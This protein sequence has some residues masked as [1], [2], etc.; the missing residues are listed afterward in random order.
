VT[1]PTG[2]W[3]YVHADDDAE[4]GR[5]SQLAR[6]VKARYELL[7]GETIEL[8]LDQD[9]LGWGE[10]WRQKVES[11]LATA[12]FFI[13][14]LTPRFF[15]SSE[16]RNELQTFTRKATNLGVRELVLPIVYAEFAGLHDDSPTDEL[17]ALVK[18]FQYVDWTDLGLTDADSSEHRRGVNRLA[19]RLRE[20]NRAADDA[21]LGA[22][23]VAPIVV[24]AVEDEPGLLE[25]LAT[26][27]ETMPRLA[28]TTLAIGAE[29]QQIGE[30]VSA[31]TA[32]LQ[33]FNGASNAIQP[34]LMIVKRLSWS[35][36]PHADRILSLGSQFETQLHDVDDLIRT[37]VAAAP[38]LAASANGRE[39]MCGFFDGVRSASRSS[40]SGLGALE[41]F[42]TQIQPMESLS[43]DLRKPLRTLRQGLTVIA[44]GRSITDSWIRLMD[45]SPLQCEGSSQDGDQSLP[46]PT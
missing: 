6:L 11:S 22:E 21:A 40:T 20:A 4:G 1:T 44:E 10:V 13:P 43:R 38:L 16:C 41:T 2:F 12:A 5:I 14:V 28:D 46:N 18:T 7:T 23:A 32:E 8:F 3:S 26:V 29:V 36:Q 17:V 30:V 24:A 25:R 19:T 39:S 33:R 31:G 34:A 9:S 15:S 45:E 37:L 42:I 27:T 35:L